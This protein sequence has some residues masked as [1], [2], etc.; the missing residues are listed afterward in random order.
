MLFLGFTWVYL[1]L[2]WR[3]RVFWMFFLGMLF[4]KMSFGGVLLRA[5]VGVSL[6]VKRRLSVPAIQKTKTCRQILIS[7]SSSSAMGPKKTN[8]HQLTTCPTNLQI[9]LPKDYRTA[10]DKQNCAIQTKADLSSIRHLL[11]LFI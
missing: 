11:Y 9:Q 5:F 1:V 10:P 8:P 6:E 7:T 3:G 4:E 2:F